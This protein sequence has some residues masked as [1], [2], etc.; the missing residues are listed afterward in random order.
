MSLTE[1]AIKYNRSRNTLTKYKKDGKWDERKE[2][3]DA[4]I[5]ALVP[6]VH[7]LLEKAPSE[8][9]EL[10]I[11][12]A[13]VCLNLVLRRYK[14]ALL[15]GDEN[16]AG[17]VNSIH[18]I[19]SSLEKF[20]NVE[21]KKKT[22]GVTKTEVHVKKETINW[23]KIIRLSIEAKKEHGESFDESKFL[24]EAINASVKKDE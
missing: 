14:D 3:E 17:I 11:Q 16:T 12:D 18:K 15:A 7:G 20:Q 4:E 6:Y 8:V 2:K 1:L 21:I 19:S 22:G 5:K 13:E 24:E 10:S 23:D 9:R